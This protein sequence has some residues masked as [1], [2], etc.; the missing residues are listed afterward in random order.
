MT[1]L[2]ARVVV[3]S[4]FV[5]LGFASL[6]H[7]QAPDGEALYKRTCAQCHD[8]GANRAPARD[9]FR[10]MPAERVMSAMETGSMITMANGR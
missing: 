5:L 9:A 4:V 8:T 1:Q 6:A 3:T 2:I 7:A 10:S